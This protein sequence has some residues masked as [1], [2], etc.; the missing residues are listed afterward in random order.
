MALERAL[1]ER[2][3]QVLDEITRYYRVS[4]EGPSLGYLAR[5]IATGRH[6]VRCHLEALARKGWLSSPGGGA[7]PRR[8][9]DVSTY[10]DGF[11]LAHG[12]LG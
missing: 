4:G 11:V 2:Q 6:G 3:A 7:I 12:R 5:R 10:R 8:R 9:H 1:T